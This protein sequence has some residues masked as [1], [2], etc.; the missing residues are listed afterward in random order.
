MVLNLT[1]RTTERYLNTLKQLNTEL[2]SAFDSELDKLKSEEKQL[3][4]ALRLKTRLDLIHS[5][6]K[7]LQMNG[8]LST[9]VDEPTT[10]TTMETSAGLPLAARTSNLMANDVYNQSFRS[11]ASLDDMIRLSEESLAKSYRLIGKLN[12]SASHKHAAADDDD[13]LICEKPSQRNDLAT[14]KT[15]AINRSPVDTTEF[16]RNTVYSNLQTKRSSS[17]SFTNP[18]PVRPK[19]V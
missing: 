13:C 19:V 2:T 3:Q 12:E 1:N 4:E 7:E 17:K 11:T 9:T 8:D 10:M 5:L 15:I 16:L 6:D 18:V 14:T